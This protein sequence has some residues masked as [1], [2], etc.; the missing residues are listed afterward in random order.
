MG[1]IVNKD[2]F[3]A[4]CKQSLPLYKSVQDVKMKDSA[5]QVSNL[6]RFAIAFSMP[7]I[8]NQ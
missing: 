2:A 6:F 8:K 5:D 1:A 7:L 3:V 4:S